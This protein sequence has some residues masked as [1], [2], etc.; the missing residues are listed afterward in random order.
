MFDNRVCQWNNEDTIMTDAKS[1]GINQLGKPT[2]KTI[3]K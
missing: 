2:N 1:I 3:Y